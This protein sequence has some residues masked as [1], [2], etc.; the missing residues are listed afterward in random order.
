MFAFI[1]YRSLLD[2]SFEAGVYVS[3]KRQIYKARRRRLRFSFS[4]MRILVAL[5]RRG[6]VAQSG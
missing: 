3:R 5:E 1:T 6:P 2:T 4:L